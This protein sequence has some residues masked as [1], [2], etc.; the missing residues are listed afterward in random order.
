MQFASEMVTVQKQLEEKGFTVILPDQTE[1][2]IENTS[3]KDMVSRGTIS[4]Q[5]KIEHD[6][7]RKHYNEIVQSDAVLILNYDKNGI[8]NYVGGNTF[9]EIGFA[10]VLGK[11]IF[12]LNPMPEGQSVF[13]QELLAMQPVV[14]DGDLA[15]LTLTKNYA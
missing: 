9:L 15:K 12:A 6:F 5:R 13:Y 3:L 14:L 8:K 2:Y 7:I 11:K 4:A 10:Y 1:T